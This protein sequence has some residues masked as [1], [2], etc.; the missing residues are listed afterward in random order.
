ML[1]CIADHV[2]A[3][4]PAALGRTSV[5]GRNISDMQFVLLSA[6]VLV[7]V[8][9]AVVITRRTEQAR[10]RIDRHGLDDL[11]RI[12]RHDNPR[13]NGLD[14]LIQDHRRMGIKPKPLNAPGD[15]PP[16]PGFVEGP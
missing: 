11:R 7:V 14:P 3:G 1:T 9:A 15:E 5:P 8:L 12:Y 6:L 2:R 16:L 13:G 4:P 10:A